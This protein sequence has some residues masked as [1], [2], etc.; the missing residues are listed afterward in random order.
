MNRLLQSLE[1]LDYIVRADA[2]DEGRARVVRFTKRGRAA[3][4]KILSILRDIEHEWS[5]EL[6]TKDFV[7]LKKLLIRVWESP[8][9]R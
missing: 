3:Y 7:Q 4:S 8:L 6:G 9:V 1:E 5:A 2:P